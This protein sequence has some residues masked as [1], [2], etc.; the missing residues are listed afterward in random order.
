MV[1]DGLDSRL[2]A[3][4]YAGEQPRLK[5]T[6]KGPLSKADFKFLQFSFV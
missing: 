1:F 5:K 2:K 6:E 4:T 3:K